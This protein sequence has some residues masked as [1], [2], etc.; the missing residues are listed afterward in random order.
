M[1]IKDIKGNH[2]LLNS[3]NTALN[4]RDALINTKS[5]HQNELETLTNQL[6]NVIDRLMTNPQYKKVADETEKQEIQT[7]LDSLN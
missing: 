1:T 5:Q 2:E 7:L 6:K 3:Y 4:L